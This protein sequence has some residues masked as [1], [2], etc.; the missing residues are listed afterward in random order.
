MK[1]SNLF[2]GPKANQVRD[3]LLAQ[4]QV[5]HEEHAASAEHHAA[6]ANMYAARVQRLSQ[7]TSATTE[8]KQ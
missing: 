7:P 3:Q 6:L 5:L 1:L 8:T 4:A 2:G